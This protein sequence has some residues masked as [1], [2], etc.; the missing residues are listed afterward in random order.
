MVERVDGWM[1]G[2][3]LSDGAR[4]LFCLPV[5]E[6][7]QSG[8]ECGETDTGGFRACLACW[9]GSCQGWERNGGSVEG[10]VVVMVVEVVG[11]AES[12][13]GGWILTPF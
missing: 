13:G 9:E 11:V 6:G 3:W 4:Q 2:R 5:L 1:G 10:V 8:G 7:E 12:S